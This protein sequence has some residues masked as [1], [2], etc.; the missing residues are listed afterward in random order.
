MAGPTD[1]KYGMDLHGQAWLIFRRLLTFSPVLISEL[2]DSARCANIRSL[3][4]QICKIRTQLRE[5]NVPI[6]LITIREGM[7]PCHYQL[8]RLGKKNE[9]TEAAKRPEAHN[10]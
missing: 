6:G 4:V 3:Q 9:A 1:A 5:H 10:S 7:K 8:I 2:S